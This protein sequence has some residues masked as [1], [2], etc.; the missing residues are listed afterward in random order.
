MRRG[1]LLL[2]HLT[3][4]V[5]LAA[6]VAC[7]TDKLNKPQD[8]SL[9]HWLGRCTADDECPGEAR[10]LCRTCTIACDET[11]R[12]G[13]RASGAE[14][15]EL[16]ALGED[17]TCRDPSGA[18]CLAPCRTASDCGGPGW[19]CR[20]GYCNARDA[21]PAMA[22]SDASASGADGAERVDA[23]APHSVMDEL[24]RD[25]ESRADAASGQPVPDTLPHSA[26]AGVSSQ[27][28]LDASPL[29]DPLIDPRDGG[30]QRPDP[31]EQPLIGFVPPT[32]DAGPSAGCAALDCGKYGTCAE[33]ATFAQCV[34][35]QDYAGS[36]CRVYS[37]ARGMALG[38]SHTCVH[39]RPY[40]LTCW[41]HN[42]HAELGVGHLDDLGDEPGEMG[43]S[44]PPIFIELP[45]NHRGVFAGAH[46]SCAI[47]DLGEAACWGLNDSGQLGRGDTAMR[48][49]TVDELGLP[50]P[51]I[52]LG[53][54]SFVE[55][56]A[57]GT[58]HSCAL[59]A[60][61]AVKCWG[62]N[63][64]GQ[65]GLGDT[66]ARG[67]QPGQM[68]D[69]L[70][71]VNL[72]GTALRLATSNSSSCA[73]LDDG[74]VRCWGQGESGQLGVGLSPPVGVISDQLGSQLHPVQL[75]SALAPTGIT[76]GAEHFCV[77]FSDG[78]VECWGEELALGDDA[79]SGGSP[80]LPIDLDGELAL[81]VVAG[82]G[83]SCAR[84]LSEKL[85]CWGTVPLSNESGRGV[86]VFSAPQRP[87]LHV[88]AGGRHLCFVTNAGVHCVGANEVGQL[89]NE[90][91]SPV[92]FDE[93]GVVP[94]ISL[95]GPFA[96]PSDPPPTP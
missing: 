56:L 65:L 51:P 40:Y 39:V 13:E 46:H 68:G 63:D 25:V 8:D 62:A 18:L 3:V 94:A 47:T 86:R 50:T 64:A 70:P 54:G 75:E 81:E 35:A 92:G 72:P 57:L 24:G 74:S 76:A 5:A 26:D 52:E 66:L 77:W 31:V 49:G 45:S 6:A 84:T 93:L 1:L 2:N 44:L 83:F 69:A 22:L 17:F 12:C 27:L 90:T 79:P 4:A 78:T 43:R 14:C 21:A 89:G 36:K 19:S 71:S 53:A 29:I 73:L 23:D 37:S 20:E 9:T 38:E 67:N 16:A 87:P 88:W 96:V 32:T 48:G 28:D 61:G 34:C 85:A 59:L 7:H 33:N 41:G 10:C 82:N 91:T 80:P 15:V 11:T 60:T 42:A 95:N 55:S 30:L 58:A